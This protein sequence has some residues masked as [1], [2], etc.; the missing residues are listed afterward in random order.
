MNEAFE[1]ALNQIAEEKSINKE[2]LLK[3]IE[4]SLAAAFRKDYGKK[5][6][7]IVVDFLPET[8]GVKVWD[9][10]KVVAEVIDPIKEITLEEAKK[11]KKSAKMDAEI[12]MDIT[13]KTGAKHKGVWP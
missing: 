1:Q 7:N 5:D 12:K 2:E 11:I 10:K 3:M 8:L 13:P 4:M 9:V 6:Q